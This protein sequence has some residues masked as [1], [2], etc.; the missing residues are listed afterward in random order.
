MLLASCQRPAE[1]VSQASSPPLPV[2]AFSGERALGEVSRLVALGPRVSGAG[3][4]RGASHIAARLRDLGVE[5]R[6]DEFQDDTPDGRLTFRNV[7]ASFGSTNGP[8][9]VILS[10][11]DT[12]AA[13][14]P[15]FVG[16]NDSG[17]STGILLELASLLRLHPP[18]NTGVLLA[19]LDGEEARAGYSATDGLHGSR[20]LAAMLKQQMRMRHPGSPRPVRAVILLDMV[21]DRDLTITIPRNS[22]AE[23]TELALACARAE[24]ARDKFG[25]Y[26]GEILDDH[27]PFLVEG[28]EAIDLIDFE[29]GTSPGRNDLWH[30]PADTVDKLS[31]GSLEAVGRV[32]VRMLNALLAAPL[33][34]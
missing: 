31:A 14:P 23:L 28:F 20:H 7:E 25:L 12:P 11:Y 19:F 15:A 26:Q 16:A 8:L 17:S 34:R 13:L 33:P 24:G 27:A 6:I 21:G 4:E 10:H 3:A 2:E 32:V 22:S 5:P 29:F 18:A 30:T 1:P 9:I